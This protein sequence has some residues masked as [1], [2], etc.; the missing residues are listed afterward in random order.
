MTLRTLLLLIL[1]LTITCCTDKPSDTRL[2][3]VENL[4]SE[5]PKEA[6]DSLGAINYDLL[7]DADKRYYD[8]LSV[9]VAD[10]SYITHS[11]DSL[12]LKV[13]DFESKHQ[14]N[15]RYPEALYY[16][17]RVYSDLGDYPTAI[18]YFYD[19]LNNIASNNV[20][21]NRLKSNIL[22]QL[23]RRFNALRLYSQA[24]PHLKQAIQIDSILCD[25][26]NIAYDLELLGAIYFH[27][28]S[29]ELSSQ[30]FQLAKTYAKNLSPK[31]TLHMQM[32][33]AAIAF[34]QN[35][36]NS[37]ISL[38]RNIP[39]NVRPIHQNISLAYASD[40]YL[41]SGQYD[42]AYI[43]ADRLIHSPHM[44]NQKS[45]YR[46]LFSQE[47]EP[48][49]PKD[50]LPKYIREFYASVE[51]A[52]NKLES[53]QISNQLS[54][55]NYT[56][57]QRERLKAE[58]TKKRVMFVSLILGIVSSILIVIILISKNKRKKLLL[59]L[60]S[61][62]LELESIKYSNCSPYDCKTENTVF[63][64][65]NV[66]ELKK[67]L[68]DQL[69]R[70][71]GQQHT[72]PPI[73]SIILNSEVYKQIQEHILNERIIPER[74]PIWNSLES[75]IISS[76]PS[77]KNNLQLLV[78]DSLK[79]H[80]YHTVLLMKCG[81]SPSDLTILL[82]RTKGTISYRRKHVCEIILGE[83]ISPTLIDY[84]IRCI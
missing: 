62:I 45:G 46:N 40:I 70:L 35:D 57:N 28:D 5:S 24:I 14:G 52:Y 61:T 9:K 83:R 72:L 55:Y 67:K 27:Q 71:N 37:A 29:L 63:N 31:D 43:F 73:P 38:I 10:K 65:S 59:D 11:S 50:S 47:L 58:T 20:E 48:Y 19:A 17:G 22:S 69:E 77:F 84:L 56:F 34:R 6:W 1:S 13:I 12:I 23:A 76:S 2:S 80:D 75:I 49:I 25:T 53:Q 41:A 18:N 54:Y 32:Y 3:R 79:L 4:S 68:K 42:S 21:S 51:D 30:Q 60:Q 7:S 66:S 74:N 39:D 33:Q 16:G 15:G 8:F 81:I 44:G 78:G 26:F 82:G 64:T 36:I